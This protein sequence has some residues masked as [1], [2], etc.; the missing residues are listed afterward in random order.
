[1]LLLNIITLLILPRSAFSFLCLILSPAIHVDPSA[2]DFGS[3]PFGS[4]VTRSLSV[5]YVSGRVI[6]DGVCSCNCSNPASTSV[7]ITIDSSS[8]EVFTVSPSSFSLADNE[9]RTVQV[10]FHSKASE[11]EGTFT[12]T[13]IAEPTAAGAPTRTVSLVGVAYQLQPNININP[14]SFEFGNQPVNSEAGQTLTIS[15]EGDAMLED[16]TLSLSAPFSASST[17]FSIAPGAS[18]SFTIKFKPTSRGPVLGNLTVASNDPDS[19]SLLIGLSGTGVAPYL[20]VSPA[21]LDFGTIPVGESVTRTLTISNQNNSN[22][23]TLTLSS[24]QTTNAQFSFSGPESTSLA[25]GT[26]TTVQ[27]TLTPA[28]SGTK[29]GN[30]TFQSNDP[31]HASNT[32]ALTGTAVSPSIDPSTL[33][34]SFGNVH[35]G[36]TA[37]QTFS[38][39]NNGSSSLVISGMAPSSSTVAVSPTT[40]VIAAGGTQAFTVTYTPQT[41]NPSYIFASLS[42]TL[43]ISNNDPVLP[44]LVINLSAQNASP[45]FNSIPSYDFGTVYV[46]DSRIG[47]LVVTNTGNEDLVAQN[48]ASNLS[49][50]T[51]LQTSLTVPPGESGI[52]EVRYRPTVDATHNATLTFESNDFF[53]PVRTVSVTGVG[54]PELDLSISG[55]EVTQAIQTSDNTV[56]IVWGKKT[57]VR[58]FIA[59]TVKGSP[60]VSNVVRNVDGLLRL[61]KAGTEVA[62]SPLKSMNGPI[63]VIPAPDRKKTNDTLNFLIPPDLMKK[64]LNQ[65]EDVELEMQVELNPATGARVP[66]LKENSYD[67]N[68]F[69]KTLYFGGNYIPTI[70]YVPVTQT[71]SQ[72][73]AVYPLPPSRKML[74]GTSLL[75]KI[76]PVPG[77]N[78]L[79]RPPLGFK[80]EINQNNAYDLFAAL[81]FASHLGNVPPPDRTFGWI[82]EPLTVG[83]AEDIPGRVAF[84]GRLSDL[85]GPVGAQLVFAHELGHTYGLCHTH[86][87][88]ATE[89]TPSGSVTHCPVDYSDGHQVEDG[90]ILEVGFDPEK[91]ETIVPLPLDQWM[92]CVGSKPNWSQCLGQG[93]LDFMSYGPAKYRR[94]I[95]PQRYKFLHQIFRD[96]YF[97]PSNARG[98]NNLIACEKKEPALL[99][100]GFISEEGEAV[101]HPIYAAES[102]PDT[103]PKTA[104]SSPYKVLALDQDGAPL[105][106]YPLELGGP[107]GFQQTDRDLSTF[108]LVVP[109]LPGLKT[110]QVMRGE[111]VMTERSKTNHSPLLSL[112]SPQGGERF[113]GVLEVHWSASDQDGDSLT[114]SVLYSADGGITFSAIAV[115]LSGTSFQ[116]DVNKL[117]GS[118]S[119]VVRVVTTDGFHTASVDSPPFQISSKPPQV[120]ILAPKE[121]ETVFAGMR[122]SLEAAASDP[123]DGEIAS[124]QVVW[125]SSIAGDLGKGNPLSAVLPLG[126]HTV[127]VTATDRDGNQATSQVQIF[128]VD[129]VHAP[130]ADAGSDQTV[131]EGESVLLDASQSNDP[132]EGESLGYMWRQIEGSTAALDDPAAMTPHFSAPQVTGD[133]LLRFLLTA[134]DDQGNIGTDTVEIAVSN[135]NF[136][137]LSLAE[138]ELDFGTVAVGSAAQRTFSITNIGNEPLDVTGLELSRTV[139]TAASAPFTLQPGDSASLTMTF[140]PDEEASYEGTLRVQSNTVFGVPSTVILKGTTPDPKIFYNDNGVGGSLLPEEFSETSKPENPQ[141]GSSPHGEQPGEAPDPGSFGF[142]GTGGCNLVDR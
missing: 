15:N 34:L 117:P 112:V 43:T 80:K 3:A 70:Y 138:K 81:F 129:G 86:T 89:V 46:G 14:T 53:N 105:F 121:G 124:D 74:D 67:N 84:G 132:D 107:A 83:F 12:A 49:A 134:T 94:W 77:I 59:S 103:V 40:A 75:R 97:E 104:G 22:S 82:P 63:S 88:E 106:E 114:S 41:T 8:P 52:I 140:T 127:S 21:S 26:S 31:Y 133:T 18:K 66:R 39:R 126:I 58:A 35:L 118:S 76:F 47:Q 20:S 100:A 9:S 125:R 33:N 98:C 101:L 79:Q 68:S 99:I 4:T 54:V 28:S 27:V 16:G 135:V 128:V 48:I 65:N 137:F 30:L 119:A 29:G 131:S 142:V 139:F 113:E 91:G 116:Y 110:I 71:D 85:E 136:P 62:G 56:P 73:R 90:T 61:Y 87:L 6:F 19:P 13:L 130:R 50:A 2:V 24:F 111:E 108:S 93:A 11:G 78:Y 1:M 44:S 37:T 92:L 102:V 36:T 7:T 10:T 120:L 141:P 95:H 5:S 69:S 25:P 109:D 96:R 72:G 51:P 42:G 23:A 122:I 55:V 57:V 45:F 32:V 123:E 60:N 64:V 17:S 38:I 115:D